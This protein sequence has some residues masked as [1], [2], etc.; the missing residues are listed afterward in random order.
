MADSSPGSVRFRSVRRPRIAHVPGP[1]R[2]PVPP[3]D[4]RAGSSPVGSLRGPG[5]PA[6]GGVPA[7]PQRSSHSS[8][9]SAA[10]H[11]LRRPRHVRCGVF[12]GHASRE[13]SWARHPGNACVPPANG[14]AGPPPTNAG[15][16]PA[17]PGRAVPGPPP[18][19]FGRTAFTRANRSRSAKRPRVRRRRPTSRVRAGWRPTSRRGHPLR[20]LACGR[21]LLLLCSGRR[22]VIKGGPVP[23]VAGPG[24]HPT[25]E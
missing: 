16:T 2:P 15:G 14:T 21:G 11:S 17:Y 23:G 18:L 8:N 1:R 19:R 10:R 22:R 13:R 3:A 12:A 7:P 6:Q 24:V 5:R 20:A 9:C 25:G 4:H